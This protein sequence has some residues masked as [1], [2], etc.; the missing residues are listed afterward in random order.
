MMVVDSKRDRVLTQEEILRV[1][2]ANIGFGATDKEFVIGEC[3]AF[4]RKDSM[5]YTQKGNTIFVTRYFG[6]L[7]ELQVF[8]ADTAKNLI[9]SCLEYFKYLRDKGVVQCTV[10]IEGS[11]IRIVN[12]FKRHAYKMNATVKR[13]SLNKNKC[14]LVVHTNCKTLGKGAP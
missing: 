12:V 1:V 8:T 11:L 6:D 9:R 7:A 4:I 14:L 2:G 5:D 13:Y 3:L 10:I